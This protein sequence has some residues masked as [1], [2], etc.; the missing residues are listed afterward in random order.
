MQIKN[1]EHNTFFFG[2]RGFPNLPTKYGPDLNI[3][4]ILLLFTS[5]FAS[6]KKVMTYSKA[7]DPSPR[8]DQKCYSFVDIWSPIIENLGAVLIEL[9]ESGGPVSQKIEFID[10]SITITI[11]VHT[12]A[13][14]YGISFR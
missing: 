7:V 2:V 1:R 6:G 13:N 9:P 14:K 10:S 4:H 5:F 8:S 3:K 12:N 11:M